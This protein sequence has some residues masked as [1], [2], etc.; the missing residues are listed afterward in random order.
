MRTPGVGK[1]RIWL[2]AVSLLAGA[3]TLAG[4]SFAQAASGGTAAGTAVPMGWSAPVTVDTSPPFATANPLS[5]IACPRA[6]WCLAGDLAGNLL[7][8]TDPGGGSAAWHKTASGFRNSGQDL[9]GIAELICP[10]TSFCLAAVSVNDEPPYRI[11]TSTDPTGNHSAWHRIRR[12]LP[13]DIS[14][15]SAS[16]CASGSG[17]HLIYSA[18]P[19][20]G[21]SSVWKTITLSQTTNLTGVSCASRSFC[22]ATDNAGIEYTSTNPTGGVSTWK[23]GLINHLDAISSPSC[24]SAAFCTALD[25]GGDLLYSTNPA[26]GAMTWQ[27]TTAPASI[28]TIVCV[29]RSFCYGRDTLGDVLTTSNPIGGRKAWQVTDVAGSEQISAVSCPA[30][31]ACAA[32]AE[33]GAQ[34]G[35]VFTTTDP[36]GG[37]PAWQSAEIDGVNTITSLNCP[38]LAFCV[39]GDDSGNLLIATNPAGGVGA[40]SRLHL[41]TPVGVFTAISCAGTSL[42][43]AADNQGDIVWSADP[44]GG[45]SA[46]HEADVDGSASITSIACPSA[47]L[48]VAGDASGNIVQLG[49]SGQRRLQLARDQ[50][51]LQ[52]RAA[53]RELSQRHVLRQ[54]RDDD[55]VQLDEPDRWR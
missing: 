5:A 31:Q 42:C 17:H 45:A 19:A 3:I 20:A 48:C 21:T 25:S 24:P 34:A 50:H 22:L 27:G 39:A 44:G 40:W 10:T 14:C 28:F 49:R 7:F 11:F 30:A 2:S 9:T 38:A 35:S 41:A 23:S 33:V 8:S 16:L 4:T 54:H 29:S 12:S 37:P 6:N 15:P 46:W 1:G 55:G 26:G 13:G 18:D 43:V 36:G 51:R 53:L 47:T 52:P 32:V